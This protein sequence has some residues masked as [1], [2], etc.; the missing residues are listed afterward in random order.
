M[1]FENAI[2]NMP[3]E[4]KNEITEM[5]T[6]LKT[7][8]PLK[9]KRA[10]DKNGKKITYTAPDFGISYAIMLPDEKALHHFGWYYIYDK[11]TQK[12]GRKPDYLVETLEEIAKTNPQM[13]ERLFNALKECTSCKTD[14]SCGKI[15]Y[16]YNGQAQVSCYGRVVLRICSDDFNDARTFFTTL[17]TLL[18]QK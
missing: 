17:N 1:V 8:R 13:A 4:Q 18:E 11:Q 2:A 10:V 9:F 14:T 5:D 7:L 6:H 15:S 12:W 3:P 16:T